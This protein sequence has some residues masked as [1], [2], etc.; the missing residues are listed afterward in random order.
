MNRTLTLLL[1]IIILS[2]GMAMAQSDSSALLALDGHGPDWI[3]NTGS[4]TG[5]AK[6]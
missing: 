4:K 3:I 6:L 5:S 1:A 2:G